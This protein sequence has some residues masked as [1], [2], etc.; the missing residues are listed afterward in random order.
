[1]RSNN[2]RNLLL[3][4]G[5]LLCTSGLKAQQ[6]TTLKTY[7]IGAQ[8]LHLYDLPSARYQVPNGDKKGLNGDKTGFDIGADVYFEKQFT[9]LLGAQLGLRYGNLTG[10]NDIEYYENTFTEVYLDGIFIFSNLDL[11][12]MDSKW[13]FYAKA[14]LGTGTFD[15]Q[16]FLI[17][18]DS[19]DDAIN[20]GFWEGH[21]G[22]G[23][24]YELNHSLRLDLEISYNTAYT[25][26]FD[27]YDDNN[28]SDTYLTTGLGIAYTF[29]KKEKQTMYG[30]NYFGEEYLNVAHAPAQSTAV[31]AADT[32]TGQKI[33]ALQEALEAQQKELARTNGQISQQQKQIDAL[34]A[35]NAAVTSNTLSVYFDF[36]S[37]VLSK[38]AK[39]KLMEKLG[40]D[41]NNKIELTAYADRLGDDAYNKQLKEKR[42]QAVVD[43]LTQLG[44]N[45]QN[46]TINLG[47]RTDLDNNND[48][49]NRR[50]VIKW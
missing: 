33:E 16:Q 43:F 35:T 2:K 46:I 22:A 32:L 34:K 39:E 44:V 4:L 21:V 25:D 11:F 30:V 18:D 12:H 27:G 24:Q 8:L 47:Q 17:S 26:G 5:V 49:L 9:P 29:G 28:G 50:V 31:P 3:I 7:S 38:E 14:G 40:A 1:M 23:V 37:S 48:F 6:D 41:H 15:A 13:N 20:E 36:D 10:A 45:K 42:A 19:P